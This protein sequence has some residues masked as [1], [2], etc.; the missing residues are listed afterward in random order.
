MSS[1][2]IIKSKHFFEENQ[3]ESLAE[4]PVDS[5]KPWP[6]NDKLRYIGKPISRIDGYDKVSGSAIYAFDKVFPRM[7]FARTLRCPFPNA[8]IKSIDTA[9]AAKL[10]G[11]LGIITYRNSPSIKWYDTSYL[12]DPHLRYEGDEVACVAAE[13]DEIANE[14]LK[15]IDVQ[16][17]QLKFVIDAAEAMKPDAYRIYDSGNIVDGVVDGEPSKYSRGDVE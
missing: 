8:Q 16:Y 4:V 5:I 15:L 10:P 2:K 11:V 9:A 14:A 3:V 12:F 6:N 13:S 1:R 17:E 7:A